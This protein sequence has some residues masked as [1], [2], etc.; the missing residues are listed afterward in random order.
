MRLLLDMR[1]SEDWAQNHLPRNVGKPMSLGPEIPAFTRQVTV[2]ACEPIVE[3]IRQKVVA[4]ERGGESPC[5]FINLD[6]EYDKEELARAEMLRFRPTVL[7]RTYGERHGTV[8]D[9]SNACPKCGAG[10]AQRSTLIIDPRYLKKKDCL[11]TITADEWIVSAKLANLLRQLASQDCTLEPIHDLHGNMME[12]WFQLKV[13]AVFGSAISP[14]TKFG[15]DYFHPDDTK[16]E[17]VCPQHCLSGLNLLSEL[18]M[19]PE[20]EADQWPSLS[21]TKN[22]VGRK[23]GWIVPA[24]FLLVTRRLADALLKNGIRGFGLDVAHVL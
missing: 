23:A 15:L 4:S 14:P 12:D 2:D 6:F 21:I 3:T 1:M 16:G 7:V 10:R 5:C 22:R 9:D 11:V 13:H 24:P 20:N 8:Y 18:Y 19:K 17:Y